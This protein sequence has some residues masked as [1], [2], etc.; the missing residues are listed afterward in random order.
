MRGED[1]KPHPGTLLRHTMEEIRTRGTGT[2]VEI[3]HHHVRLEVVEHGQSI[4]GRRG[5]A[6]LVANGLERPRHHR[7]GELLVLDE[8]YPV[9]AD[10]GGSFDVPGLNWL[11]HMPTLT[12]LQGKLPPN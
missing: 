6:D 10:R 9:E 4:G 11:L 3:R 2:E 12:H 7:P 1:D 5:T 8:E